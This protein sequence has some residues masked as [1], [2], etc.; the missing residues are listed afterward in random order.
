MVSKIGSDRLVDLLVLERQNF[1]L[2]NSHL[3]QSDAQYLW[4]RR[5]AELTFAL[6]STAPGIQCEKDVS[7]TTKNEAISPPVD[8]SRRLSVGYLI[9]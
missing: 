7:R 8:M 2:E 1:W 4:D 3:S 9:P 6:A 5:V